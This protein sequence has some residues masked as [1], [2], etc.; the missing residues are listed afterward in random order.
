MDMES[1]SS[2]AIGNIPCPK[3][4]ENGKDRKG[5]NLVQFNDGHT[6][7]FACGYQEQNGST[8]VVKTQPKIGL[9][10]TG[11]V[12][13]IKDRRIS[14]NIVAKF[15]VTLEYN[16]DGSIKKHH[17][18]Y[19][20]RETGKVVGTKVKEIDGKRFSCT[21]TLENTSLFGQHI[22]RE[23]G[24]AVTVVEGELD[25]LAVAEMFDGK[26]PV[27]SIKTGSAGAHKDIK[28]ELEWLETFE[29]VYICFDMDDAGRKAV[30]SILPLFSHNKAKVVSLPLKDAGDMLKAG[31]LREF[32]SAWWDAKP[33]RPVDVVS[34]SDESVWDAF[35]KR[36][37]EEVIPFP[38]SFGALNSMM[39]GGI[40]P[41]EVTVIGALT[42]VGKSTMVYNLLHGFIT[43]TSKKVGFVFLEASQGE[44]VEKLVSI[45]R[46]QNIDL[47]AHKDR[48]YDS[49]RKDYDTLIT[50]DRVHMVQH[51]GSSDVDELF[52]KMRF[53]VKGMDCDII[54]L[55]PLQAAVLSNENGTIDAFM[56]RCLK[57]A[58][59][60]NVSVI[61]VSHMRKPQTK[62][63]HDVSEYD[64]K[65][66]GSI[67]QISFNTILLSRDK[68]AEDEYTKNSTKV[69]L[70]KCRRTGRTGVAGWMYYET[71]TGRMVAGT[72]PET[73]AVEDEEF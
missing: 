71:N 73:K 45:Q 31:K 25:A 15:G 37:T 33:Y 72:P 69:Q 35:I 50:D 28:A 64:M 46:G 36:G 54:I 22:W 12:G 13:P 52:G 51:H 29:N 8:T 49:Y 65:G 59:E 6:H 57:L 44:E 20:D 11:T 67:N 60:T 34:L 53:M 47:I 1:N 7:C 30:D 24:R 18:P 68:M 32:T 10:M 17:Y 43:E 5:N 61:I 42:S 56:D 70:V 40:S 21:G 48:D 4:R 38:K 14:E 26:W 39:N 55:D 63:A 16:Q 23:G 2:T 41:G 66:S 9:E 62:D 3:C 58:K 27:V 19:T